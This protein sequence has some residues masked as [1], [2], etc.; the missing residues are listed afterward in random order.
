MISVNV[1]LDSERSYTSRIV[2]A[3]DTGRLPFTDQTA[4]SICFSNPSVPVARLRTTKVADRTALDGVQQHRPVDN[5]RRW[6][7]DTV[8][9]H[10]ADHAHD[11]APS[12]P[13]PLLDPPANGCAR[14]APQ[15]AGEVLRNHDH[16]RPSWMSV[17]VRSRPASRR[18]PVV[19]NTPGEMYLKRRSGDGR[20]EPSACLPPR[21]CPSSCQFL[22]SASS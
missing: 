15:L 16:G 20:Q 21:C 11:F 12:T 17:Q 14:R 9:A 13:G 7:V 5:R 6:R 10:V 22:P 2:C 19:R 4:A 1:V 8:V 18:V 3:A